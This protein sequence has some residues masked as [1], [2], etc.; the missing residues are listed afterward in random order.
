MF[1]HPDEFPSESTNLTEILYKSEVWI[2]PTY[3]PEGLSVVHGWEEDNEWFQD[4]SYRKNKM[5]ANYNGIFDFDTNGY[6][7]DID[8]VDLNRN[9]D[10]NWIFGDTLLQ[11]CDPTVSDCSY[12]DDYDYYKGE[13]P[14]SESETQAI[15]KL[16]GEENFLLSIAYHSSRSGNVD[17]N[18]VYPWAWEGKSTIVECRFR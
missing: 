9:Y 2:I 17:K 7:N 13:Y 14:E 6:G 8:G 1:L 16:A 10:F 4:V 18:V 15:V 11:S 5:D 12:N 3:N